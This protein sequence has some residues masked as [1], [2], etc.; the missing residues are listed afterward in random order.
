ML[1]Y[2]TAG[3]SHG[4]ALIGILD[5][6]PAGL[7]LVSER[8]M[9]PA[10]RE[11]QKGYG[12][13]YRQKIESDAAHI[14]SGVRFG[15]TTGAPIAIMIRNNDWQNWQDEMSVTP[16][17]AK[18]PVTI[19]RPGHADFAGAVKYGH[20]NDLRNVFERAS[21]RETALRVA[22]GAIARK[23]LTEVGIT[24][25]S[26]VRSI[27][28][29]EL[30]PP[31][32]NLS[33]IEEAVEHSDVRTFSEQHA[34]L[35]REAIDRAKE[36]G[37]TLGGIVEVQFLGI[38]VGIGSTM[39]WHRKLDAQIAEAVMSV[40]AVKSVEIGAGRE[41]AFK[42]GSESHDAITVADGNLG[43][44][45]NNSGG[46]EGGMS[47]GEPIV[48]RAAIKPISTLMQPL[49]SVD[50]ATGKA[51]L[52]HIERSDVCAVPALSV[53]V[54]HVAALT[55]ANAILETFGG[56]TMD[57]LAERIEKRRM[58]YTSLIGK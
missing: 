15:M 58:S 41:L 21:A 1:R 49:P 56:D 8:D 42:P 7:S 54:E 36:Q 17:E 16:A 10:L 2:Q 20:T 18:K 22:L 6:I 25:I 4:E 13:S 35:M 48:I 55:L 32:S 23:M 45:S 27:G 14:L 44:Y 24:S 39:Q 38:P 43:R 29:I 53:I 47:N 37:D 26:Y 51:A 3:E 12:R 46:I 30:E 40:Q 50:L 19:P 33:E 28:H 9:D 52:A 34:V 57:E 11:R 31:T 5:G